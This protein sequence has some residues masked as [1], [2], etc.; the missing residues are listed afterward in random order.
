MT[1]FAN[2][3]R[4]NNRIRRLLSKLSSALAGRRIASAPTPASTDVSQ[5][6]IVEVYRRTL[7]REPSAAEITEAS[8]LT[9]LGGT[10]EFLTQVCARSTVPPVKA[11]TITPLF[12]PPGHYY[13]PIVDVDT[14]RDAGF[15][16]RR[17]VSSLA[18]IQLDE[19]KMLKTFETLALHFAKIN[20]PETDEASHR[21]YYQNVFY[22]Y[23]DAII[24]SSLLRE[25]RPKRVIEVGSGFSSAVIL[26]TLD[27]AGLGMT[28]CTFIEPFPERLR[29]LLLP[30]DE[31]RVEIIEQ[32]IQKVGHEFFAG[33]DAGDILFIDS[34]HITKT[35]SDVNYELFEILP[36][37][38]PGVLIHF[39]DVFWPFE[40]P[41][42][43]IFQDNR[44]W[45]ELYI[46]RAFLMHNDEYEILYFNDFFN[47]TFGAVVFNAHPLIPLNPGGGL[48]LRKRGSQ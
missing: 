29:S 12:V 1:L 30:A 8:E 39:H 16:A 6:F 40:Y 41:E 42:S 7:G 33:L 21:Y 28:R 14:L 22:S 36:N 25:Y 17:D 3:R 31:L 38:R 46:L 2:F 47:K 48:W 23:G 37:L 27:D 19:S 24:L 43:W 35:G 44:S 45:N 9:S 26:D 13:S 4:I 32:P 18:S 5:D 34:T 10:R 11:A 20:F 15:L